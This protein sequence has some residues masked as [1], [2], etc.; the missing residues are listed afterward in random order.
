MFCQISEQWK[1]DSESMSKIMY[2]QLVHQIC[3]DHHGKQK[4]HKS[5]AQLLRIS[6]SDRG[7]TCAVELFEAVVDDDVSG[8]GGKVAAP[9]LGRLFWQQWWHGQ[10]CLGKDPL[11]SYFERND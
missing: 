6:P 2:S 10:T 3:F 4:I 7:E 8:E 9:Y 1:I 11:G 5:S